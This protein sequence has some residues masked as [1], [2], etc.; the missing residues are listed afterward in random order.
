M[1]LPTTLSTLLSKNVLFPG[2][3]K[4]VME[5][6]QHTPPLPM[7]AKFIPPHPKVKL[8]LSKSVTLRVLTSLIYEMNAFVHPIAEYYKHSCVFYTTP[9]Q[10]FQCLPS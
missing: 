2:E 9:K 10:S 4:G 5:L 7:P 1:E 8:Q 6:V 3:Q